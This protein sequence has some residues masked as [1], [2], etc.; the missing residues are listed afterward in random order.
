MLDFNPTAPEQ[1]FIDHF[2]RFCEKELG[3]H[4]EASDESGQ[5]PRD[6]YRKLGA[7]GY[8]G[9]LHESRFGGQEASYTLATLAQI[10]LAEVCGSSFFSVGASAGLFGGPIDAHGT[11]EQKSKYLPAIIRGDL[12]GCLA[13]TEPHAGSDVSALTTVATLTADGGYYVL[14]GQKTYITNAPICDSAIVLARARTHDGRDL[15]LTH[16]IVDASIPGFV[17]GK[18]MKKMG[19]RGSPTGEIFFEDARIS[20]DQVLG[21]A[22]NTGKGFRVT[23]EAFNKE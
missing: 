12:I 8:N 2:R 18:S 9:L 10:V 4:V 5:L 11:E 22:N 17:R 20:A 16:F 19:L 15:G 23:M 13:V 14:N 3:P 21:G 1:E 6:H 7:I